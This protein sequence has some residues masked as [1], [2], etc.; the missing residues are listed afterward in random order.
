MQQTREMTDA[1]DYALARTGPANVATQEQF[2]RT[3]LLRGVNILK[4][5]RLV[6]EAGHWEVASSCARQ[7][8]EI[9]LNMEAID[10]APSREEAS[11][12]FALYGML[13]KLLFQKAELEY[14]RD[15]GRMARVDQLPE[16][17][18]RLDSA[19]FNEFRREKPGGGDPFVSSWTKQSTWDLAKASASTLRVAQYNTLFKK[20][21]AETHGAPGAYIDNMF[22]RTGTN[23]A[24]E[25]IEQDD[26]EISGVMQMAM[27]LFLDLWALVT[28]TVPFPAEDAVLWTER[29]F[30]WIERDSKIPDDMRYP[31]RPDGS[32]IIAPPPKPEDPA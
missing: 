18:Q 29:I 9:L 19:I 17:Q 11:I 16:I 2:E 30:A 4:A 15:T 12:K 32:Y 21:S 5:A 10:R 13:Q 8:Y 3:I 31:K 28:D 22:G 26:E 1:G 14:E 23:W 24:K 7:L 20:W 6:C 25:A 27:L